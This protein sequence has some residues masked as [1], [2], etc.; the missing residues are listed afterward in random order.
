MTKR[1]IENKGAPS[2]LSADWAPF[3]RKLAAVFGGLEED[4]YLILSR[5]RGDSRFIQFAGQ[6]SYG[7][8]V[9][10]T[11]ND[12]LPAPEH[13]DAQQICDVDRRWLE[14]ANR[15]TQAVGSGE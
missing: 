14:R 12:Y 6:G 13:Y 5:K 9:E 8:R 4:Q 10:T 7:M 1:T 15:Q 3:A 2:T 11:S